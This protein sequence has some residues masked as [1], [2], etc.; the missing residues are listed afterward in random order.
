MTFQ[1]HCFFQD[2]KED[3]AKPALKVPR[4]QAKW[5]SP[6]AQTV[7]INWDASI[8]MKTNRIG[9]GIVAS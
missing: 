6:S 1:V 3:Q 7:K 8:C 9:I 5:S 4:Q 2:A